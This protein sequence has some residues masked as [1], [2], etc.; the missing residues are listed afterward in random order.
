MYT[1]NMTTIDKLLIKIVNQSD[2]SV[3]E[4]I[5]KRDAR[6]LRSLATA[7][8]TP[9]FITENQSKLLVKILTEHTDKFVQNLDELVESLITPSWS[10]LFREVDKT[11][12]MYISSAEPLLV[13]EFAFSSAM[14]KSV[15]SSV[16][17]INGLVQVASGKVYSAD[18]TEEN[19]ET[20][21]ELLQ[22]MGFEI[23][24]KIL[25]FYK[26]IKSWEKTEVKNQFLLTNITHINFQKQITADLG[27]STPINDNVISDRSTRYQYFHEKSGKNPEKLTEILAYRNSTKVWVDRNKWSL[28]EIIFSLTELKRLPVLVVFDN[29]DPKK[30]LAEMAILHESLENNSIYDNVGIYFRL[31]NDEVGSQFNKFISEHSYN[32]QLDNT[33]K[34]VGVQ[35]GKIPKFF[36]KNEWRP[37]SVISVG[38]TLRQTKTSV[39]AN[40]CDLIISHTDTQPIIETRNVWE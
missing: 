21:V 33:T 28:D 10:K 13:I 37:M 19:I 34:V 12:K 25:D 14:R 15:T 3:E 38:N 32:C 17:K 18:L 1:S 11:K 20:L 29:N 36:L 30:C 26:I 27:I 23:E 8:L 16:K 5:P 2:P 40:L 6:V 7:I 24:E 39:Y 4:V 35:N 9:G 31:P 22:P